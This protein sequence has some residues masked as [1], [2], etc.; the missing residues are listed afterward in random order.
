[1]ADIPIGRDQHF[2]TDLFSFHHGMRSLNLFGTSFN[3][4]PVEGTLIN[5][6]FLI[7]YIINIHPIVPPLQ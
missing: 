6:D 4:L 3:Y 5:F 1:V 2:Q 7:S